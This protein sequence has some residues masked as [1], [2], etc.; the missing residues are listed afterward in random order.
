MTS[1][2]KDFET[3]PSSG[4]LEFSKKIVYLD[5]VFTNIGSS[6]YTLKVY[7][8]SNKDIKIPTVKLGKSDSKYR[9]MIDG[10][11]G[12]DE[13]NNGVG[14]GRIFNN[15]ELLAK[16]SLY[17]FIETTAKVADVNPTDFLYTD[18]IQFDS[19]SNLQK[20]SLVTL[21]QDAI[22]LYPQKYTDGTKESLLLGLDEN[23]KEVRINGFELN[24]NDPVN[25]NELHFTNQKPYVIYGY[26]GVPQGKTLQID[27]GARVYFHSE[28]GMIVQ[29]NA[30]LHINGTVSPDVTKPQQNEVLFEG[31]RLEPEFED[32]PG[33]WGTIWL[34]QGSV[35]NSINH[36]TL[37]NATVGLL[38]EDNVLNITN[39]QIY[40]SANLGI[41][42]RTTTIT[43]DNLVI[44]SAGQAS[45]ACSIGGSYQFTHCTFNNNWNSTKQAAVLVSNFEKNQDGSI[46]K[47]D[48]VQATF[49]NCIIYGSNS[50]ELSLNKDTSAGFTTS[51]E[52][53]L[54]KFNDFGT[55]IANNAL[56][57]F[58][59][60]EQFGNIKNKDPKFFKLNQNK[61]NIDETSAAFQ[62]GNA[63]YRIPND[64]L[65]NI[66]TTTP[67]L[68]AYQSAP[69]P[70]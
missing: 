62:K 34:R 48:L 59:R 37:K 65:G 12:V 41:L 13:D 36:L 24:E 20:V 60:N 22:F 25:G 19:G 21:I 49:R 61:L 33:Q 39:S 42:G 18:E 23:N 53:C 32:T 54:I 10:M 26:A 29:P 66:R 8:R 58:I 35:N 64:I 31:D 9:M 5:T 46:T 4:S 56:Y 70:K 57:D 67:D 14:D 47:A 15:V 2:R 43:G 16:D 30:S 11:T 45:I 52:N 6:T 40:N 55:G 7:N 44:N 63:T 3:V 17:V 38:V 28:S 68:G 51:F 27:A 50:V 1:C 69:F